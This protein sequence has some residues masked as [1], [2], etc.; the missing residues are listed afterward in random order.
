MEWALYREQPMNTIGDTHCL[1][2]SPMQSGK[3]GR[4]L[5]FNRKKTASTGNDGAGTAL[6]ERNA[7]DTVSGGKAQKDPGRQCAVKNAAPSTR[8]E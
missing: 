3:T 1:H 6:T 4:G 5:S 8:L 7:W 2:A